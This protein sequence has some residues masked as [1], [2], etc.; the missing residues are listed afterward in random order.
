[1]P[2][3][4]VEFWRKKFEANVK[5]DRHCFNELLAINWRP[6]VVWQCEVQTPEDAERV[7][8]RIFFPN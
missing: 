7:L 6:E 5:R 8:A 3:S 4:N 1:M 2:K